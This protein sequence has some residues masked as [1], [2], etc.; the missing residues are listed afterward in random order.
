MNDETP[1][2]CLTTHAGRAHAVGPVIA[3]AVE[4]AE[5]FGMRCLLS[6][7][8]EA[9]AALPESVW[10]MK[11]DGRMEI[12]FFDR[13][14]GVNMKWFPA[15]RLYPDA[16]LVCIDDDR[17]YRDE[18]IRALLAAAKRFPEDF[19]CCAW[20]RLLV[21]DTGATAPYSLAGEKKAVLHTGLE[22]EEPTI[23]PP[24]RF[25]VEHWA[26]CLHPPRFALGYETEAVL[27]APKDDDSFLSALMA[28]HGR[29]CRVVP[30]AE[31]PCKRDLMREGD[32]GTKAFFKESALGNQRR[33]GWART[34]AVIASYERDFRRARE[35]KTA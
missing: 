13:D 16:P 7:S 12:R 26:A 5:R 14:L 20:R 18:T 22:V 29:T 8:R 33:D 1:V 35:R 15:R 2:L 25:V 30:L 24:G 34:A 10:T 19:L 4:M 9:G 11:E 28:R 23:L 32:P 21:D 3:A 17:I 27:Y 31:S 6:V